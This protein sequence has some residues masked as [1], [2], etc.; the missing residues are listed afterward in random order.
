[1]YFVLML[2]NIFILL[3]VKENSIVHFSYTA[4]NAMFWL[5]RWQ[6][7]T[8][9]GGRE[10]SDGS[11]AQLDLL[12]L[13]EQQPLLGLVFQLQSLHPMKPKPFP[14]MKIKTR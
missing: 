14:F 9:S 2:T 3:L 6:G 5:Q 10:G 13:L 8:D 7:N 12:R 11:G 1:M 4:P